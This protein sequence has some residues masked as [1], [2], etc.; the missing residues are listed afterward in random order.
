M[1]VIGTSCKDLSRANTSV[2][3]KKQVLS[4][5]TSKG[6]SAHVVSHSPLMIVYETVD[7]VDDKVSA[8]TE[9]TLSLL[10]HGYRGQ[11][12]MTDAREFGLPCRRRRLY[13]F[14]CAKVLAD[15]G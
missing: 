8:L 14:L 12:V 9:T 11:K 3:R 15:C 10:E 5:T 1:L 6:G 13:V 4:Q 7:A 2:D